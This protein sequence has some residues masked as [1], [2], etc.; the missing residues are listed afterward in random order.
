MCVPLHLQLKAYRDLLGRVVITA[1]NTVSSQSAQHMKDKIKRMLDILGCKNVKVGIKSVS[2]A[3]HPDAKLYCTY[4]LAR[5]IV[6]SSSQTDLTMSGPA[7]LVC[8]WSFFSSIDIN[9]L[10][11]GFFLVGVRSVCGPL[12]LMLLLVFLLLLHF[13]QM[14]G[15]KQIASHAESAFSFA[16]V[17]IGVWNEDPL[18]GELL[19]GHLYRSCPVAVPFYPPRLEGQSDN[20]YRK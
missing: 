15:E 2:A 16:A 4:M 5:H 14:Q 19:L 1:V 12:C 20:D 8:V 18:F 11:L 10:W 3:D 13:I 17:I 7:A 6:V 9:F